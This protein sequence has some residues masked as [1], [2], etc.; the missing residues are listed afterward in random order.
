MSSQR[1]RTILVLAA[2]GG[3]ARRT[4]S[5]KQNRRAW[6]VAFKLFMAAHTTIGSV[7]YKPL[8]VALRDVDEFYPLFDSPK[9]NV[10]TR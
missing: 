2:R 1:I 4:R 5:A 6:R 9:K 3:Q 10:Y 7:R 8:S